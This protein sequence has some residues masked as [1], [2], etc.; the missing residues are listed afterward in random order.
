MA[1]KTSV[2]DPPTGRIITNYIYRVVLRSVI[3][4]YYHNLKQQHK[5]VTV[6]REDTY[7]YVNKNHSLG[8]HIHDTVTDTESIA[9]PVLL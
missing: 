5:N 1:E 7:V 3:K 4:L 2:A 8:I 9:R 6:N